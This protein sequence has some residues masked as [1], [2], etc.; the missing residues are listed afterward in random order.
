M[1]NYV[2]KFAIIKDGTPISSDMS[3]M[4]NHPYKIIKQTKSGLS[5]LL[6]AKVISILSFADTVKRDEIDKSFWMYTDDCII[7]D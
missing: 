5:L 1:D 4:Y 7:K 2:G 6:E 3:Q